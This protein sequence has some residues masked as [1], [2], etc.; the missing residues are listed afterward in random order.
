M[1]NRDRLPR[2]TGVGGLVDV[3][4][5]DPHRVFHLRVGVD[6]R[7]IEGPLAQ[8]AAFAHLLPCRAGVVGQEEA[9]V[10]R[11]DLGIDAIGVG[12]RHRKT[13]L[14]EHRLGQSRRPRN[15]GPVI[16]AVSRLE[17]PAAWSTARH[18]VG[19]A[20]RLPQRD[21]DHLRVVRI[22]DQLVGACLVVA[23][24]DL[25]PRL[26]AVFRPVHAALRVR[27]R[28]MTEGCDVDH[29]RVRRDGPGSWQSPGSR[30]DRCAS[31]SSRHP[32]TYRRRRP[33]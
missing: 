6:A 11:F 17:D 3:D 22:D 8:I 14:A 30:S 19:V 12:A 18:L 26:A 1:R 9:A 24:Q 15:L 25:L 23:K 13:D 16:A 33:E 27:G 29:I 5:Q 28:V 21:I 2:L 7:V 10:V 31:R 32:S 4:V 20:I